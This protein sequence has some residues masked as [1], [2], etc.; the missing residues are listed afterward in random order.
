MTR[1]NRVLPT[2]EIV[3]LAFRGT[4]M[5]NRGILHDA[6][7][8]LRRP[9][10][11]RAW[12]ACRTEFGGRHRA[13]MAPGRYTEL[14]F[15]DEVHALAAGHRPCHECRRGDARHFLAASGHPRVD[16]LDRALDAERLDGVRGTRRRARRK[17]R[18]RARVGALPA[19]AVV[20]IG[21]TF[22]ARRENGFIAWTAD[23]SP[24]RY[25]RELEGRAA[26]D[27]DALRAALSS[28]AR[29]EVLTPPTTRAALHAGYGPRW[30]PSAAEAALVPA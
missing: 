29:L 19:G 2:G 20:Q 3:A 25:R 18:D 16:A 4:L 28:D 22:F 10:A 30:H 15:L 23:R 14:F 7:G 27:A 9:F 17:R 13:I 8:E 24:G 12:I 1:S 21:R 5:G 26:R 6:A 11:T